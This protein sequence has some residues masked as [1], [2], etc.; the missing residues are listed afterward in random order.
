MVTASVLYFGFIMLMTGCGVF[1][2]RVGTS[3]GHLLASAAGTLG[4]VLVTAAVTIALS[5]SDALWGV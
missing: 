1:L 4:C 2:N 3:T 5:L